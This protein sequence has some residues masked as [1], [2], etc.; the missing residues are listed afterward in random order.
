MKFNSL[1]ALK[2]KVAALNAPLYDKDSDVFNDEKAVYH[3][4]AEMINSQLV[5]ASLIPA[6][7]KN[8]LLYVDATNSSISC[9]WYNPKE[10]EV[11]DEYGFSGVTFV[12][13]QDPE[14]EVDEDFFFYWMIMDALKKFKFTAILPL[15]GV[16]IYES[17]E[18]EDPEPLPF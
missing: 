12:T 13:Y 16:T 10:N 7:V 15:E 4:L 9:R 17:D 8:L 18:G 14:L 5:N 1:E 6:E 3:E 11:S 2:A